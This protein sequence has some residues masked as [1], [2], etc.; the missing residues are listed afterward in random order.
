LQE[1]KWTIIVPHASFASHEHSVVTPRWLTSSK[2][3][4]FLPIGRE[5]WSSVVVHHRPHQLTLAFEHHEQALLDE[6]YPIVIS[7][8]NTDSRALD[9]A[10]DVL[11]QPTAFDGTDNH[12]AVDEQRS[13][14]LIKG[15]RLGT[16]APGVST[17][18]T[19]HLFSTGAPGERV[20]DVSLQ[21]TH[22]TKRGR[23]EA[24]R[25]KSEETPEAASE[26]AEID[27]GTQEG[28]ENPTEETEEEE[29][30]EANEMLETLVVPALEALRVIYDV[31]YRRTMPRALLGGILDASVGQEDA[32]W[33]EHD[34][35]EA[36]VHATVQCAGPVGLKVD[37]AKLVREDGISAR[38]LDAFLDEA[39]KEMFEDEYLPGDE[40]GD[41]CRIALVPD[42][43]QMSSSEYIPGPGYYE[44][45]WRRVLQGGNY[46][47][48]STSLFALPTLQPPRDGL[49][50][51]LSVP[52]TAKLHVPTH[53]HLTIRNRHP[54]RTATVTV[55]LEGDPQLQDGSTSLGGG[56]LVAGLRTGRVPVLLPGMEYT[57]S[58]RIIP[59][60]CGSVRVPGVKIFDMRKAAADT[61]ASGEE[62]EIVDVRT[63]WRSENAEV[64]AGTVQPLPLKSTPRQG[65]EK[66]VRPPQCILV[67]P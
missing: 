19:L 28:A 30:V 32:P 18:K 42:E 24:A 2:P 62:V 15:V 53:M 38:I 67:L 60:E 58:W 51:L 31:G 66:A 5:H 6:D 50:G 33:G 57:L 46:G 17:Q 44:I 48:S 41:S 3:F 35:G 22:R 43:E 12:I 13:A 20:I 64:S 27:T 52:S 10:I 14:G 54:S 37:G 26:S 16:L 21:S 47:P 7:V 65:G 29:N 56:I 1:G 63:D 34:A 49:I 36:L 39:G 45:I 25:Y 59:L 4:R 9:V 8:T 55:Q 11:L 23:D 40:F 61:G